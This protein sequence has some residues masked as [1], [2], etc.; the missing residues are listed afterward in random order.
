MS[1]YRNYKKIKGVLKLKLSV[2]A[3]KWLLDAKKSGG[4]ASFDDADLKLTQILQNWREADNLDIGILG[5][6]FD[7]SVFFRT[8]CRYGPDVIRDTMSMYANSYEPGYGVNIKDINIADFGNVNV[9]HQD[10]L[11]THRRVEN[12]VTDIIGNGTV[13]LILG[14]DHGL[15]YPNVKALMNNTKGKVGVIMLDG[16]LDVRKTQDGVI[17]SGT[18]FRRLIEEPERNP[19]DP[20][21][22][23]EIGINGWLSSKDYGDY[24]KE[25][26]ITII[27][28]REVHERGYKDVIK[29]A[30]EIA[31]NGTDA[32][33]L[34]VDIDG[35]DSSVAPGTCAPNPGGLTAHEALE[36][37]WTVAN[38][39]K[40]AGMDLLEVAPPLDF[41]NITSIVATYLCMQFIGG[42]KNQKYG[43]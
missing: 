21:N 22:F 14:G 9:H 19:L 30:L 32:I 36:I 29:Q 8:G 10:V 43:K 34:S 7:T 15:T 39:P 16:H 25:K 38:H 5:I 37:V 11:E 20:K 23:V 42:I 1:N 27:P 17:S 33:W 12:I 31:G 28:A 18:P 24:C 4:T 35:L 40:C 6:P 41:N 26:G 13:P 3:E 2:E